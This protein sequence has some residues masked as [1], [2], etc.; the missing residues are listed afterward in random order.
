MTYG[1]SGRWES[2]VAHLSRRLKTPGGPSG[3]IVRF[4]NRRRI[5]IDEVN[6]MVEDES[7]TVEEAIRILDAKMKASNKSLDW[8]QKHIRSK[9]N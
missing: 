7:I 5:I 9:N 4:F 8:L 3:E 6:R 2:A 1:E